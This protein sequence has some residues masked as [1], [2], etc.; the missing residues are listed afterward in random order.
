VRGTTSRKDTGK[1]TSHDGIIGSAEQHGHHLVTVLVPARN[2]EGSI[3]R[4]LD[5]IVRQ[6]YRHLQIVV[7]DDGS[8]DRTA[9]LVRSRI[10]GDPRIE[11]VSIRGSGIPAALNQGL[12]VTRGTWLVRVDAHATIPTTY[13]AQLVRHLQQ[14]AWGGVGGRKDGLGDTAA[15]RA[16]AAAM[17]SRFGV[18]NSKY[19]YAIEPEGV[20]HLP[21]G[22]YRADLVR[23]LGGWD[24]RLVANE[25]YEFDYRLRLSGERLLLDPQIVVTWESRQSVPDLWRQYVRYGRG[26]A[27]VAVLHPAS[28]Q[29]RHVAA[30]L[31]IVWVVA[32]ALVAARR[33]R[34]AVAMITPYLASLAG[35]SAVTARRLDGRNGA[36]HIP[37]AFLAMHT[38]WGVGFWVGLLTRVRRPSW[39][40][41]PTNTS[42]ARGYGGP[43]RSVT[44]F[45]QAK[46][47]DTALQ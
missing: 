47:D 40:H 25:D 3:G 39:R 37:A 27:D 35:A 45:V 16:I 26:K 20:D 22:A 30:P 13:V 15:G 2:E 34:L 28:L 44:T 14:G 43:W 1:Q 9:E 46:R 4:A 38:G 18:G 36:A 32:A 6:T 10:S 12:N 7:V 29:P 24:E 42:G 33:P 19:H 8:T 23:R 11:L 41:R 17:G 5:S 21:F 31:F